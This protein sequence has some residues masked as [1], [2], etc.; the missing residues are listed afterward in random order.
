[1]ADTGIL[2]RIAPIWELQSAVTFSPANPA[3][4]SA[5]LFP[6]KHKNI[7][8]AL[9]RGMHGYGQSLEIGRDFNMLGVGHPAF[10]FISQFK[11]ALIRSLSG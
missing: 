1:M 3:R 2:A 9:T 10:D 7:W 4:H 11:R 5:L 6:V 8:L